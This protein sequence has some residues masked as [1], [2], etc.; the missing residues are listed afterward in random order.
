MRSVSAAPPPWLCLD[1]LT[2]RWL[3]HFRSPP[4]IPEDPRQYARVPSQAARG[5]RRAIPLS[6]RVLIH[7]QHAG[8]DLLG[9]PSAPFQQDPNFEG[10]FRVGDPSDTMG[11]GLV[12]ANRAQR[13]MAVKTACST[14][15]P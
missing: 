4:R 1:Q 3:S 7:V 10:P 6:Y 5:L 11:V 2:S 14:L 8:M 12:S 9:E 13:S 15:H